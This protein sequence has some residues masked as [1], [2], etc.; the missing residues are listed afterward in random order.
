MTPL[1]NFLHALSNIRDQR[2]RA[3]LSALGIAVASIAIVT[4][5]SIAL[6]VRADITSQVEELGVNTLIVLP[7]RIEE[8]T[9]NPN[10]GGQSYLKE[11]YGSSLKEVPGVIRVAPL[12]FAGGGIRYKDKEAYPTM[13]ATTSDWFKMQAIEMKHGR[14]WNDP[15]TKE[16]IALI[17]S[18]AADRL[19]GAS[20][21]PVGL[22][23]EF[24]GDQY[25]IVGVTRDKEGGS[26][27]FSMFSLQNVVYIPYHA[28]KAKQTD[29]QTDRLMVQSAPE[30]EPKQLVKKLEESLAKHLDR[31][32]YSVL[33]NEDLLKLVYKLMG[34]LTWLLVGLTSIALFVGGVG[35]MTVMLMSVNERSREIG[36]RKTVGA[37][38]KD[39]FWQFLAE[40][41]TLA[42]IGGTVGFCFSYVVCVI[43]YRYTDVKPSV[44][45]GVALMCFGVCLLIGSIFGLIPAMR[46][47]RQD[48]VVA[49]RH[50]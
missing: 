18:V 21:D 33:T 8:G 3:V 2:Q 37:R 10:L 6:G 13:V 9:F 31:Q 1:Q 25:R 48:P 34:I 12:T 15:R 47:A 17:G 45:P 4:L 35:I 41:I 49:L 22:N 24:N 43:L 29:M 39:V 28:A 40:A 38:Q 20:V 19:F 16:K 50:E 36:I 14:P 23:I 46:A 27:L 32:Q 26:G 42:L 11:E 5:V 30:A 7:G 44:T